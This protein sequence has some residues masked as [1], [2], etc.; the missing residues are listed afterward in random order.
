MTEIVST[1]QPLLA[2]LDLGQ[3][4]RLAGSPH[5]LA[6][7]LVN[8]TRQLLPYR[9]AVLWLEGK[10]VQALSGLLAP[11]NN[12]PFI[13]YLQRLLR[14]LSSRGDEAVLRPVARE[15]LPNELAA[16][17]ADWLSPH[18]YLLPLSADP[19]RPES[20]NAALLLVCDVPWEPEVFPL[21]GEWGA[22]W[23][24]AWNAQLRPRPW[25]PSALRQRCLDWF[26]AGADR[27]WWRRPR[28]M[29]SGAALALLV[30]P[31]RLTVLA[32]GE[33]VA[34]DPAVIRAPLDGVL[35][36]VHVRPNQVVKAGD[37]LFSFD[38][39][40]I[41]ARLE[42]ARQSLATAEAEYRQLAQL[43]LSDARSKAQMASLLGKVAEKQAETNFLAGQFERARVLA[44]VDGVALLDDPGELIGKPVQTGERILRVANPE[45]KE[46]EAWIPIGD[47]IP[48]PEQAAVDLFLSASPLS[49]DSGRVRY[50]AHDAVPRPD[51]AYAYRLRASLRETTDHRIGMKGTAKVHGGWVPLIYWVMRRPIAS[52]RQFLA[53]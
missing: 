36:Q 14:H 10:G 35:A 32:P 21:L 11:E 29:L 34:V 7:L 12:S 20:C 41:A 51:G 31:V 38:E 22:I 45:A 49:S 23:W 9:Q 28:I 13:Q 6:F 15:S 47:A 44:P 26:R 48:L 37:L 18:V 19:S 24:H 40:P 46:I 16:E 25:S 17:W 39:A 30:C 8:D 1:P 3:R 27:V 42:V 2:L 5:E 53:L 43:A 50:L 4:A 52:I 33:L